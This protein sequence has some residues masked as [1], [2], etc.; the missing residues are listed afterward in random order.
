M[1]TGLGP[2]KAKH[3]RESKQLASR[4]DSLTGSK[5][6]KH[7][8]YA[9]PVEWES[10]SESDLTRLRLAMQVDATEE[11]IAAIEEIVV[12]L[13]ASGI[14][15]TSDILVKVKT[16]PS[17]ETD[18]QLKVLAFK[19]ELEATFKQFQSLELDAK[20]IK[21]KAEQ[22]SHKY[23][24]GIIDDAEALAKKLNKFYTMLEKMIMEPNSVNEGTVPEVISKRNQMSTEVSQL[25]DWAQKL[26]LSVGNSGKKK[27]SESTV[28]G[29]GDQNV[30][31]ACLIF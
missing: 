7:I 4:A 20:Q 25:K 30:M 22:G 3:W 21:N 15:G 10:I 29:I 5:E 11:E 31:N 27:E 12:N 8:E 2:E 6:E 26:G 9:V 24:A 28:I 17:E 19:N 13:V 18:Q 16:E 14:G 1:Y 23:L